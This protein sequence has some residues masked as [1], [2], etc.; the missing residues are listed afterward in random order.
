MI[1]NLASLLENAAK[2][3]ARNLRGVHRG[4]GVTDGFRPDVHQQRVID[5]PALCLRVLA[6]AGSG[7]T[8]TLVTKAIKIVEQD[9]R[10]SVL[11]LTFTNA[12]VNA[13]AETVHRSAPTLQGRC[14]ATTLNKF[15]LHA[16]KAANPELR[17]FPMEKPHIASPAVRRVMAGPNAICLSTDRLPFSELWDAIEA[18]KQLGLAPTAGNQRD[19][20][21]TLAFLEALGTLAVLRERLDRAE[22]DIG[23]DPESICRHWLPFWREALT[24]TRSLGLTLEDQKFRA[25]WDQL[26]NQ[27][28]SRHIAA[29]RISHLL[30]DEFQDTNLLELY[31]IASISRGNNSNLYIVG[32]DDQCIYEWKGCTPE[33]ITNPD[34]LLSGLLGRQSKFETVILEKNYRC[35][36]NIVECS[37]RLIEHNEQRVPKNIIASQWRD[38]NIRQVRLPTSA[39]S[40][41]TLVRLIKEV[42][43]G[44]AKHTF[45]LLARKKAQLVPLQVLLA[46]E[47]VN[48]FIPMDCNIF[49]QDSFRMLL[50]AFEV[51][52]VLRGAK[53]EPRP[54]RV[55]ELLLGLANRVWKRD[56]YQKDKELVES[57]LCDV[58]NMEEGLRAIA[59]V[60][61]LPGKQNDASSIS[62]A[63]Q[64]FAASKSCAVALQ[65]LFNK[66]SGFRQDYGRS[67]DDIFLRDPPLGLLI[68]LASSYSDEA[69]FVCDLEATRLKAS[70]KSGVH[71]REDA[72]VSLLTAY[73]A[74]GREFDTVVVL[75]ANDGF[76]PATQ[77][78]Q[79][80]RI[81]EERR[82]FYVAVTRAQSNLLLFSSDF[83]QGREHSTS[84]FIG[85]MNLD[86]QSKIAPKVPDEVVRELLALYPNSDQEIR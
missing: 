47:H 70:T 15:G 22:V 37:R 59:L 8:A 16:L 73:R 35:P 82:L 64:A 28:L 7:K 81:E 3:I 60:G 83:V 80:G 6:P 5:S 42:L 39:V 52:L 67:K 62:D 78:V 79:A 33:F 29:K 84:L 68:D 51:R 43:R 36:R 17:S 26:S 11:M 49:L 27:A 40:M 25:Y 66:F 54:E 10:A 72:P 19:D 65:I 53:P 44:D 63:I 56:L 14:R 76:W 30:V 12:G 57:A 55:R 9:P 45:A 4:Q 86:E 18:T 31:L 34:A 20:I 85:E 41:L 58:A 74:K 23:R 50:D 24:E 61:H 13:F 21:A 32:D 75:D 48:F 1:Q 38:A 77:A 46:K 71:E 2:E 69:E